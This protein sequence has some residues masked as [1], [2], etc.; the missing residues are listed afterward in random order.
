MNNKE[1]KK[2][3]INGMDSMGSC[4]DHNCETCHLPKEELKIDD[5]PITKQDIKDSKDFYNSHL[6]SQNLVEEDWTKELWDKYASFEFSGEVNKPGGKKLEDFISNLL[7]QTKQEERQFILNVLDGIDKADKE[8]GVIGG[9][10]AIR[11]ALK[12]R[13]I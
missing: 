5:S 13:I 7:T 1:E 9:T 11:L 2:C 10:K 6:P 12:S 8:M 3:C 4:I